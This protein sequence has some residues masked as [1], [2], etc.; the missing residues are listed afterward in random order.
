MKKI[1]RVL[2]AILLF[3]I[4]LSFT[5]CYGVVPPKEY[6]R[7]HYTY[8]DAIAYAKTIDPNAIVSENGTAVYEDFAR[9]RIQWAAVINGIECHVVSIRSFYGELAWPFYDLASDYEYC[10][11]EKIVAE[12]QPDWEVKDPGNLYRPYLYR[13]GAYGHLYIET[14][15]AAIREELSQEGL[16]QLW[17]DVCEIVAVYEEQSGNLRLEFGAAA[18]PFFHE[19]EGKKYVSMT[20]A[21]IWKFEEEDKREFLTSYREGWD[22]M[23]L[24]LPFKD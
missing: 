24:D 17:Q 14:P 10:L 8:E 1:K 6:S 11:L 7:R 9:D 15:Y 19:E 22:L 3:G 20:I 5:A 13:Y 2:L 16:E 21:R 18:Q 4:L 12:K 23:D